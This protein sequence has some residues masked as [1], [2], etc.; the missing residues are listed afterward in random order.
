MTELLEKQFHRSKRLLFS[1][2][3]SNILENTMIFKLNPGSIQ[4]LIS[5]LV[6]ASL[7]LS[8]LGFSQVPAIASNPAYLLARNCSIA[9]S[10]RLLSLDGVDLAIC[11]P[12][13]PDIL[14]GANQSD[15]VQSAY[16][17]NRNTRQ[18]LSIYAV[19]YGLQPASDNLPVA[20]PGIVAVYQDLSFK[21]YDGDVLADMEA[22]PII[23]FGQSVRGRSVMIPDNEG[24]SAGQQMI[25]QWVAEAG[26]RVWLVRS[27]QYAGIF[28]DNGHASAADEPIALISSSLDQPSTSLRLSRESQPAVEADVIAS[29]TELPSPAWWNGVCDVNN[30]P[31]SSP[32]G[33]S[34]RGV[35]TC[36]PL[37]T[38]HLVNFGAGVS[39]YEWQCVEYV[40]R[41][42]YLAFGIVPYLGN[43]NTVVKNYPGTRL[44]KVLNG[45]P[46]K[47]PFAGDVISYNGPS[48]YGHASLVTASNIDANGNGTISI[49]EQNYSKTGSR[50]HTVS[51]W[52]INSSDG[53]Y[54]WLHDNQSTDN[55]PAGFTKCADEGGVCNFSATADV[56]YGARD[57]FTAP[58]SFLNGVDC[59][60]AVF[61]DPLGGV[62]KACYF[63]IASPIATNSWAA[64]YFNGPDHWLDNSN[65]TGQM[66]VE[67]LVTGGLDKNYAA[68]APCNNGISDNWVAEYNATVNFVAGNYVFQAQNDDGIKVWVNGQ[69]ILNRTSSGSLSSACPAISLSGSVP[70][71]VILREEADNA[72][73]RLLWTTDTSVCALPGSFSKAGPANGATW[74]TASPTLSWGFS[75]NVNTYSYCIDTTDNNACDTGWQ[76]AGNSTSKVLGGLSFDTTYYWQVRSNNS[77]GET[78]ADSGAWWSFTTQPDPATCYPLTLTHTGSGD[79]PLASPPNADG[80]AVGQYHLGD[81]VT[82]N[83]NPAS[84]YRVGSWSATDNDASASATNTVSMP[85]RAH[86]AAVNYIQAAPEI[87][88]TISPDV[89]V[90]D[91]LHPIY[92]WYAS[93]G[94]TSYWITVF[95]EDTTTFAIRSLVVPAS[96]CSGAPAICSFHPGVVLGNYNYAFQVAALNST[97]RS[98]F[99]P[100]RSFYV[101]KRVTAF[102]S[103]PAQDGYIRESTETSGVG[104]GY[105][106][107]NATVLVVGDDVGNRQYRAMLS[108]DTGSLPDNAVITSAIL[109]LSQ[110]SIRGVNPNTTHGWLVFDLRQ[111]Y[112][113]ASPA[114]GLDD[115]ASVASLNSA[116]WLGKTPINGVYTG[117]FAAS[118]YQHI[119][120]VG[121]TQVRLRFQ[122]D[123]DNDS[124]ADYLAFF[125]AETTTTAFRPVL[126]ISYY[127]P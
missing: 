104:G 71:R 110:N 8:N 90:T 123:D 5:A 106:N 88:V 26:N 64:K 119:N 101:A 62:G 103:I 42:L 56:V 100:W 30:F 77:G 75:R 60:N 99:S 7:S 21:A 112:F 9:A 66:C 76:A 125:S 40:K 89:I 86:E 58:R 51:N 114:Q 13:S 32:L 80:C 84:G 97:G 36:G 54:G 118:A 120:R 111:P 12:F 67:T 127:V 47:G 23:L 115:F 122:L 65:L 78:L 45:T 113:G 94:A 17:L 73:V 93:S 1:A 4:K 52:Y 74:Q 11:F 85:A 31:G 20:E 14:I 34:Y 6:F 107:S 43:G 16:A 37:N 18:E 38:N 116:G 98:A 79:D 83:A 96:Y 81:A 117:V 82:L 3:F 33:A 2:S 41:Y 29:A 19:P 87:P 102:S 10:E 95:N 24:S 39:Q 55:P 105:M 92:K 25:T 48:T 91:D 57:S 49:A 44:E 15:L 126:E 53:A 61:G 121:L 50:T 59:N 108:F 69:N 22:Q 63:K 70:I 68:A 109:K 72:R 46:N 35:K 124:I 27:T 28:Q